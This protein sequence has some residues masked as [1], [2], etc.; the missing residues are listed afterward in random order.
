MPGQETYPR[1]GH[2]SYLTSANMKPI[3]KSTLLAPKSAMRSFWAIGIFLSLLTISTST[4]WGVLTTPDQVLAFNDANIEPLLSPSYN[5]PN[6]FFR[7]WDNQSFFGLGG[8][9]TGI[10][11]ASLGETVFGPHHYRKGGQAIILAL[12]GMAFYWMCRK[13]HF[14]RI[15]SAIASAI[16]ILTGWCNTFALSGL[17]GRPVALAF[18]ALALGFMEHGR[19]TRGW[20]PYAIA[21]GCLGLCVAEIPD[22]GAFLA[23]ACAFIF[24]W[25]H[26]IGTK[27]GGRKADGSRHQVANSRLPRIVTSNGQWTILPKF[28]LFVAFSILLG[29]QTI[30]GIVGT[31][32]QGV[33]QGTEESPAARYA[34]ATQWSIPPSE[35]WNT[36]SGSYFGISM[37]SE[38]YPYWGRMGQSEGWDTTH[39]GFRNFNMTGWHLGIVPCILLIALFIY[40]FKTRRIKEG[41]IEQKGEKTANED[42]FTS[43]PLTY[44]HAFTLM[45]FLGS[46]VSLMLMWGRYFPLYR[47][48]WSLPYMGTIRN[49]EKWNG[50]FTLFAILGVAFMLDILWRH[51]IHK[52]LRLDNTSRPAEMRETSQG[53]A[54]R[55]GEPGPVRDAINSALRSSLL[56]A[57]LGMATIALL[58]FLG[59][60]A[61]KTSFIN[62]LIQDGYKDA[63]AVAYDNAIEACLKVLII[64]G[65]AVGLVMILIRRGTLNEKR[66]PIETNSHSS[67]TSHIAHLTPYTLIG[68]LAILSLT[69]LC[70]IDSSYTLGHYYKHL[71]QPNPLSTYL[72]AHQTEG[73]LKLLP[74]QNPLLNNL[75]M[76]LIQSRGYDLFDPISISRMPTDYE[77]L[78]KA[79][80][81]TPIRL[82]EL[83]S[84]RYFLTLPGAVNEL[85]KMDNNRG[86]F[87]ERLSFGV[88][89]INGSYLPVDTDNVNQRY[90]RLVEFTG[91]LPKFH[92]AGA[93]TAVPKTPAGEDAALEMISSTNFDLSCQAIIHTTSAI[94]NLQQPTNS[95]IQI[96]SE[97][98]LDVRLAVAS[99]TPSLL[100]RSTKYD[101]NWRVRTDGV[102]TPLFRVNYMFQGI[103]IPAGSHTVE[104][105]YQP[106]LGAQTKAI[107]TR[108]FLVVLILF[109]A[110]LA[111]SKKVTS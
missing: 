87:R 97:T 98:S 108:V 29:W 50:P 34:W 80:E 43:Y 59:T 106:P 107:A 63:A 51:L 8:G 37:R 64:S 6:A 72:E 94:Q 31:Q 86:R 54:T 41:C 100:L 28:L 55:N 104:F 95:S 111:G 110:A 2:I 99:D 39:Q 53:K 47:L 46:A 61:N 68:A 67:R 69:D 24:F 90:L 9:Q 25:T 73:R 102:P 13:Y 23:I 4:F 74:P 22:V 32:I 65:L 21:G 1:C 35:I 82:W 66:K 71:L 75:R 3:I 38:R 58:I 78:F 85:N 103:I 7:T 27:D 20:L 57:G 15:P 70:R 17:P 18:T 105:S 16:L 19:Q 89:V 62:Q 36:V 10:S 77:A 79:F 11:I 26:W 56:W 48:F 96:Q 109:Y 81:K 14:N 91:A 33:K 92:F 84:L 12:C 40:M 44:P 52:N 30:T 42:I 88:G 49:P 76:T 45:I 60:S 93:V 83:G 5:F 101:P